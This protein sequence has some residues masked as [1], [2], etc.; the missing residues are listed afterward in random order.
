MALEFNR[1]L[2]MVD[3]EGIAAVRDVEAL[4]AETPQHTKA[5]QVLTEEVKAITTLLLRR[6]RQ[7]RVV[8]THLSGSAQPNIDSTQLPDNVQLIHTDN[9]FRPQIWKGVDALAA[10]GMHAAAGTAGFAAHT[11]SLS[12]IWKQRG[13]FLSESALYVGLAAERDLPVLFVAGDASVAKLPGV[14]MAVTKGAA[15]QK[16]LGPAQWPKLC[17]SKAKVPRVNTNGDLTLLFPVGPPKQLFSGRTL[18][19]KISRALKAVEKEDR[20]LAQFLGEANEATQ[21]VDNVRQQ[22]LRLNPKTPRRG[23]A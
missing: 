5:C 20:R 11:V 18:F 6:C 13:R 12:A 22:L 2:L 4:I 1:I 21:F 10:W 7:V 15:S 14:R 23:M 8:D 3:L 17:E 16:C 19:E 9:P